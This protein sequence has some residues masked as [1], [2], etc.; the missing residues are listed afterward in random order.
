MIQHNFHPNYACSTST[1]PLLGTALSFGMA[2]YS[3]DQKPQ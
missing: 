2:S 1:Q 3:T